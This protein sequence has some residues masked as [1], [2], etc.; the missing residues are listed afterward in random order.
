MRI[1]AVNDGMTL[2]RIVKGPL[3]EILPLGR[4]IITT[5]ISGKHVK[6]TKYA[7]E[8]PKTRNPVFIIG[9]VPKGSP[10]LNFEEFSECIKLSNFALTASICCGRITTVFEDLWAV[11]EI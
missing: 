7:Q 4:V 9:A 3:L 11:D 10:C 8:L 5:S 2:L 1:R 6:L